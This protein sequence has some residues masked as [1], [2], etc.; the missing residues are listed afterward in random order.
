ML[1]VAAQKTLQFL[2][3]GNRERSA[4]RDGYT[5]ACANAVQQVDDQLKNGRLDPATSWPF[6]NKDRR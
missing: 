5:E 3:N 2:F 1:T 6:R 4:P